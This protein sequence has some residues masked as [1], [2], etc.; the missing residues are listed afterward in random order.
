MSSSG[1][2]PVQFNGATITCT[3]GFGAAYA[4]AVHER[5]SAR[6]PI[7]QAKY[8]ETAMRS[9]SGK[10]TAFVQDQIRSATGG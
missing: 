1:V 7:G 10:F 2:E 6:H 3:I 5:L 8:L 4:A 9:L